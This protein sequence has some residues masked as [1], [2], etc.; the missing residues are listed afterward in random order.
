MF[1]TLISIK[2]LQSL[3]VA[4]DRVLVPSLPERTSLRSYLTIRWMLMQDLQLDLVPC[5]VHHMA[6]QVSCRSRGLTFDSLG[7][8]D[9]LTRRR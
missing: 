8:Q 5:Q 3:M 6:L 9:L 1:R 2:L 4:G 7:E